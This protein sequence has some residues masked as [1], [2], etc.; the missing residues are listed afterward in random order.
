SQ[1]VSTGAETTE[2]FIADVATEIDPIVGPERRIIVVYIQDQTN[3]YYLDD[4]TGQEVYD[5]LADLADDLHA[6]GGNVKVAVCTTPH[7]DWAGLGEF[8]A[9][10][11]DINDRID[12][13]NA[14]VLAN[15]ASK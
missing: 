10:D 4:A 5:L 6:L 3:D 15:A 9:D 12:A 14:L 8:P 13:G 7:R 2:D 11:P 1:N